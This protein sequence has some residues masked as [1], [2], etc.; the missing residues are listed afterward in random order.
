MIGLSGVR[1]QK[2]WHVAGLCTVGE[3]N[4]EQKEQGLE[5]F[6]LGT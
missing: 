1:K 3:Q 4:K 2:T 5:V 6:H